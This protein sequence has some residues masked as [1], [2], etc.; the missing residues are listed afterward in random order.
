MSSNGDSSVLVVI[1]GPYVSNPEISGHEVISIFN[2]KG[3]VDES[4]LEDFYKEIINKDPTVLESGHIGYFSEMEDI[5]KFSF[6]ICQRFGLESVSLVSVED[7]NEALVDSFK[8][9]DLLMN[10]QNKGN[11]I[12]NP[13]AGKSGFFSKIFN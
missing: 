6:R 3:L 4:T 10:L 2:D 9:D 12:P 13:D 8:A 5:Q 7:Y 1:Y 11:I